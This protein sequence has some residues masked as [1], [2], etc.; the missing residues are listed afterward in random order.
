[1]IFNPT[2]CVISQ[3]TGLMHTVRQNPGSIEKLAIVDYCPSERLIAISSI[4]TR[5]EMTQEHFEWW[6]TMVV[7]G[8]EEVGR[9]IS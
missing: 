5:L 6:W 1:M 4:M 8:I 3:S 2:E 7:E 9:R